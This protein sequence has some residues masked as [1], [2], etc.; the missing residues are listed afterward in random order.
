VNELAGEI[1]A[2]VWFAVKVLTLAVIIYWGVA[3]ARRYRRARLDERDE[4]GGAG[5]AGP[6][7]ADQ[8]G[9]D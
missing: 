1:L 9:P 5:D 4:D 2:W 7:P 6:P 3:E 8:G